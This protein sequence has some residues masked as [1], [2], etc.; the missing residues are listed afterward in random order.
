MEKIGFN[1]PQDIIADATK[2][3]IPISD[4]VPSERESKVSEGI[5]RFRVGY[6]KLLISENNLMRIPSVRVFSKGQEDAQNSLSDEKESGQNETYYE[7]LDGWEII[8]ARK[9]LFEES[10]DDKWKFVSVYVFADDRGCQNIEDWLKR[11][12]GEKGEEEEKGKKGKKGKDLIRPNPLLYIELTAWS[13]EW[14]G[15]V[16]GTL[17][18]IHV[19]GTRVGYI[20]EQDW[21]PCLREKNKDGSARANDVIAEMAYVQGVA[22]SERTVARYKDA[23]KEYTKEKRVLPMG[24]PTMIRKLLEFAKLFGLDSLDCLEGMDSDLF[25][26]YDAEAFLSDVYM[27]E[28]RYQQLCS[29]L[30]RNK[31]IILQGAPGVGKTFAARR[32]AWSI[33]GEKDDD[34]VEFVQFHQSYSYEDFI[35]GYR[36]EGDGFELK[37]GIFY[38][39]C[40]KAA[41]QPDKP[42]F[43][44]IDEINRGNMSKIFGELLT[45]IEVDYRGYEVD[46]VYSG[47]RFSVPRNLH[48][49]GMMNTADRS[50][51]MID[52]ALRRRFKFFDMDP[53]FDADGFVK[54]RES[55]GSDTMNALIKK[56]KE[57]N[58]E[59]SNDRSLGKGFCIGHSYFCGMKAGKDIEE[60]CREVVEFDILPMLREYWFDDEEKV[61]NW[62]KALREVL[63]SDRG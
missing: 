15:Y 28:E 12:S 36:P 5:L 56:I 21:Y 27:D 14:L 17:G 62:A 19:D 8:C 22:L 48:I 50:L 51:A 30:S 59:I 43:F 9:E 40:Q 3:K 37:H 32:L 54:Y 34:C 49:I 23:Y 33:M 26:A 41:N 13:P 47:E 45:L 61:T 53:G 7:C 24:R 29:I 46:L 52:Y 31:N 2:K 44:I 16:Y 39:F 57:L 55:L 58:G 10:K 20:S 18:Q 4:I 35:M 11:H 63:S 38:R 60:W 6:C 42:F 1:M 25:E